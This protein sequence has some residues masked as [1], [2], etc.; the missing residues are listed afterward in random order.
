MIRYQLNPKISAEQFIDLLNHT[1]LGERRPVSDPTR[2]HDMLQNSNLIVAA[3]D[4][5]KLVG[6]ARCISDFA[7]CCYLSDLAVHQDYQKQGIGVTFIAQIQ[8]QLHPNAKII[9][10]SAPQATQY[11]PHIGFKPHHSAWIKSASE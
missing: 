3:W 9:L 6:I 5:E 11:Y 1:T 8:K 2:I 4:Q 10:L 7:Y